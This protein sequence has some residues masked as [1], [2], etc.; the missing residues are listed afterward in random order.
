MT[1]NID[2]L[3]IK[4]VVVTGLPKAEPEKRDKLKV[5]FDK[6][7]SDTVGVPKEHFVSK[8]TFDS[9]GFVNGAFIEFAKVDDASKALA[10]LNGLALSK[11]DKLQVNKWSDFS[12]YE[13]YDET[14]VEP[15]IDVAAEGGASNITNPFLMD[16]HARPQFIVKAGKTYD[17]EWFWFNSEKGKP[18]LYRKPSAAKDDN[19]GQWTEMDRGSKKLQKGLPKPFPMWSPRGSYL[20]TQHHSGI[21]VWGGSTMNKVGEILETGVT[22]VQVSPS[23]RYIVLFGKDLNVYDLKTSKHLRSFKGLEI[24][25][26][27]WPIAKFNADDS[28]VAIQTRGDRLNLYETATMKL[29]AGTAERQAYSVEIVGL[30]NFEWSPVSP[31]HIAYVVQGDASV[32]WRVNID[33]VF[34]DD[35]FVTFET[36]CRRNFFNTERVDFLWH[37]NGQFTAAKIS[38]PNA[39]EYCIFRVGTKM[40]TADQLEIKQGEPTRFAWQPDASNFVVATAAKGAKKAAIHFYATQPK[41]GFKLLQSV[42]TDADGLFWA[43]KGGR[44]AAVSFAR[45]AIE[46]YGISAADSSRILT[47]GK[48][49]HAFITH[50]EWDPTGRFF[51]TYTTALKTEHDNRYQIYD[52]NCQQ[53]ID[54]KIERLS[55]VAWRPLPPSLLSEEEIAKIRRELPARSAKYAE[56]AEQLERERQAVEDKKRRDLEERY[57]KIMNAIHADHMKHGYREQREAQRASAPF[58]RRINEALAKIADQTTTVTVTREIIESETIEK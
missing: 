38:K 6:K 29:L 39:I 37:P 56:A 50:L 17:L 24:D 16:P 10:L 22:A 43:P 54:V 28:V 8:F 48:G 7:V 49:D 3:M 33:N 27:K 13:N 9:E 52:V 53:K 23:E 21:R 45:S 15:E 4:H 34:V 58:A 20:L 47:I 25:E 11:V 35:L 46:L 1:S 26:T 30:K 2:E 36:L 5:F 44:M 12:K 31:S 32:G 18:E 57:K 42:E 14:Y 19:V 41:A 40:A 55:H 51:C